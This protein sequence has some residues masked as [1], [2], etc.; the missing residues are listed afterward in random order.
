MTAPWK[1][2]L[3]RHIQGYMEEE[4][5]RGKEPHRVVAAVNKQINVGCTIKM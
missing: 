1:N 5:G 4:N 3:V 2:L